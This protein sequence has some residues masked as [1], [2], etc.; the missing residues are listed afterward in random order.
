MTEGMHVAQE[1]RGDPHSRANSLWE[2]L[3]AVLDPELDEPITDLGFVARADVDDVGRA[4]VVIL[5]PT[6]FCAPNFVHVMISDARDAALRTPGVRSVDVRVEGHFAAAEINRGV[7]SGAGFVETFQG[8]AEAELD[9][10]RQ[11]FLRRAVLAAT[12]RVCAPLVSAGTKPA[13][14]AALALGELP[15]STDL[16][17][18]RDR[19]QRLGLA[20]DPRSPLVIDPATGTPVRADELAQHLARCRLTRVSA[21]AN[22]E[23]CRG[24]FRTRY[25]ELHVRSRTEH[26]SPDPD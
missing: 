26:R 24:L 16:E 20:A 13:D 10:L 12:E 1:T 19:R 14:L 15:L 21:E 22:G 4:V 6:Y 17:R 18:L 3:R 7:S 9:D 23:L 5:L 8:L 2:S 11:D 25:P